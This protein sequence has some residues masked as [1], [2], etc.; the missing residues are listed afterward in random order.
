MARQF[1]AIAFVALLS[2]CAIQGA[3]ENPEQAAFFM[4]SRGKVS[5]IHQLL[6]GGVDYCKVTQYNLGKT[7]FE[8][9]VDYDGKSCKVKA[10]AS[11]KGADD[12]E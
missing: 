1:L 7:D 2:G 5:I 6:S 12:E 11:D 10:K 4:V 9:D 3:N 8:A